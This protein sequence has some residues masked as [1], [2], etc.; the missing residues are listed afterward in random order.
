MNLL[1]TKHK[2]SVLLHFG[3]AS[4]GAIICVHF[5]SILLEQFRALQ[6]TLHPIPYILQ[7]MPY[8][9]GVTR[10]VSWCNVI[11]K[12]AAHVSHLHVVDLKQQYCIPSP[13]YGIRSGNW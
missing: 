8:R 5:A 9:L 7:H 1:L 12:R 10:C 11:G 6:S 2:D 4:D 13:N 3:L